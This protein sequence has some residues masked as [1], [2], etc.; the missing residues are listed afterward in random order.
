MNTV[1]DLLVYAGTQN[2]FDHVHGA[3]I[4]YPHPLNESR[5]NLKLVKQSADL[6]TTTMYNYWIHSHQFHQNH[7]TCEGLEQLGI[8][9]GVS[10]ELNH[11]GSACKTLYVWQ[12]LGEY[13]GEIEGIFAI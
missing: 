6:R 10:A 13:A 9:H 2:H 7:V 5:G 12:R 3:L 4:S 8:G 1:D 11:K